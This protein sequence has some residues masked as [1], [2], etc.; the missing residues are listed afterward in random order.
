MSSC[1]QNFETAL[2]QWY[3]LCYTL[4]WLLSLSSK[5]AIT[6]SFWW[7]SKCAIQRGAR[8]DCVAAMS[9]QMHWA[10]SNWSDIIWQ[11]RCSV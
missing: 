9:G 3:T 8:C 10:N 4:Y 5:A 6:V 11:D 7:M 1:Q 2:K